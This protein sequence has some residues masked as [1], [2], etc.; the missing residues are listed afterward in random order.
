[1]RAGRAIV[2]ALAIVSA[3]LAIGATVAW[4][5]FRGER[6][7]LLHPFQNSGRYVM[8]WDGSIHYND[9]LAG[10]SSGVG[11]PPRL[12]SAGFAG[13]DWARLPRRPIFSFR[14]TLLYAVATFALMPLFWLYRRSR[15]T[16]VAPGICAT[17]GYDLR[18][19]PTRCPEC[20]TSV[21]EPSA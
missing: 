4:L 8:I 1:M 10:T 17:C 18:A 13:I 5:G 7:L 20:G 16:R 15:R 9:M 21:A 19:T 6:H 14:I 12:Q 11:Q 2:D 3:L